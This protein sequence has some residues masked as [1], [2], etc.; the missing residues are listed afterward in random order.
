MAR[1]LSCKLGGWRQHLLGKI[2]V[3]TDLQQQVKIS[4]INMFSLKAYK[5]Y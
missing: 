2:R 3:L 5:L 1:F 4:N